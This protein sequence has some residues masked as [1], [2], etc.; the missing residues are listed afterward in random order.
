MRPCNSRL[1]VFSIFL[2]HNNLV[3]LPIYEIQCRNKR[4]P[5]KLHHYWRLRLRRYNVK[6]PTKHKIVATV[7]LKLMKIK[8][9]NAT[10]ILRPSNN[11]IPTTIFCYSKTKCLMRHK[12]LQKKSHLY[13]FQRKLISPWSIIVYFLCIL[14]R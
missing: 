3:L 14:K 1:L 11:L 4:L 5:W 13:I 2:I 10:K 12:L 9:F 7:Y 6:V 8:R